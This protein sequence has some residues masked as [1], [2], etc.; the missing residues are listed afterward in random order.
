MIAGIMLA[1]LK[2]SV[3]KIKWNLAIEHPSPHTALYIVFSGHCRSMVVQPD[4]IKAR[5][6]VLSEDEKVVLR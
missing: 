3:F 6:P 2:N 4:G 1:C 5:G